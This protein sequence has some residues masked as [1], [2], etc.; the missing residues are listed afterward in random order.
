MSIIKFKDGTKME[1]TILFA[2]ISVLIVVS[3]KL[4]YI[5]NKETIVDDNNKGGER[6]PCESSSE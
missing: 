6:V 3:N 5:V 1:G 4:F 2:A